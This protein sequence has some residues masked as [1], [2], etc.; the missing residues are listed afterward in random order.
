MLRLTA[1][2]TDHSEN[3]SRNGN[4][5]ASSVHA[6]IFCYLLGADAFGALLASVLVSLFRHVSSGDSW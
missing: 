4:S 6:P 2:A 3:G 5:G 1:Q